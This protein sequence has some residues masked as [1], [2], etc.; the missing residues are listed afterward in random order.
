VIRT[1]GVEEEF[2][3]V[4]Q[5][6]P[7]LV[8]EGEAVTAQAQRADPQ[9][10]YE[11]E[12][13]R[14]QAEIG[15]APTRST[16]DL[17][18]DLLRLRAELASAAGERGARLVAAGVS[19]VR[20]GVR[21]TPDERY[22]RM[23]RRFAQLGHEQVT[24]GMHVH[25]GIDS[26]EEGVAVVDGLAPYLPL[27]R[28]LS[29]NSPVY[30]E[31]DTGY[32]SWRT[33]LWGRWPTAG[34][35]AAFGDPAGYDAAV[36]D[37]IATGAALDD[38][39]LYFDARLSASYPTVEV[40]VG[41]VCADAED[42]VVLAAMMRALVEHVAHGG[43]ARPGV[44]PELLEAASWRAARYGMTDQLVDLVSG[45]RPTLTPAWDLVDRLVGELAGPLEEAGDAA[46]VRDGLAAVRRRGT[47]AERQRAALAH[48]VDAVVQAVT[49]H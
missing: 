12:L 9:G 17:R 22:E 26:R 16:A 2:L 39:M 44:R 7:R 13:V 27:F 45:P 30:R 21:V 33:V 40:R 42:A 3:L 28:A 48:G 34:P 14:P 18:S 43:G 19:P 11:H 10:Q 20:G 8:P 41:D 29:S 47:G 4:H 5:Q 15:T 46:V 6:Q 31:A 32:A 25:V 35:M 49:V 37:L 24:C 1:V 36:E 23:M 38:G